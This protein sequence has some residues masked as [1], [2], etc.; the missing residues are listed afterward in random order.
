MSTDYRD[1]REDCALELPRASKVLEACLSAVEVTMWAIKLGRTDLFAAG[2]RDIAR[3]FRN[4]QPVIKQY[5]DRINLVGDLGDSFTV[6]DATFAS[7]HAAALVYVRGFIWRIRVVADPNDNS[8][9]FENP[10]DGLNP[11]ALLKH[12]T[13]D[14]EGFADISCASTANIAAVRARMAREIASISRELLPELD[15][16]EKPKFP[17]ESPE[18]LLKKAFPSERQILDLDHPIARKLL[19][20]D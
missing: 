20:L 4:A 15:V 16:D 14:K 9:D 19:G 8:I 10:A 18:E 3:W 17:T 12:G 11:E 7:G 6:G 13:L 2:L 1:Q 5:R